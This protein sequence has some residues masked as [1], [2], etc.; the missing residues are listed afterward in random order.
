MIERLGQ[1]VSAQPARAGLTL[2]AILAALT[3]GGAWYLQIVGG[4]FPCPLCLEQRWPWYVAGAI[5]IILLAAPRFVGE[6][7]GPWQIWGLPV[8]ALTMAWGAWRALY[9]V[10]V[11]HHWWGSSCTG[12]GDGPI[13]IEDLEA[14]TQGA[15]GV[16]C[17]AIQWELFGI[18]LAGF[19][20][21][22]CLGAM[23]AL[24]YLFVKARSKAK[25]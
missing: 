12:G 9:H 21:A 25:A 18:T 24:I 15:V 3:L 10:G 23:A 8:L 7:V 4:L 5:A 1:F 11:E 19:N 16:P 22:I 6:R 14:L 13:S 20:L 17:D 2:V